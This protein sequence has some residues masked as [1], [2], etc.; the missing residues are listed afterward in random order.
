MSGGYADRLT[1]RPAES[2]GGKLGGK[3]YEEEQSATND[4]VVELASMIR[5]SQCCVVYTGAGI[6]TSCG[7]PDFRGPNGIWTLQAL[8]KPLPKT[9]TTLEL[10]MPSLTHA[11]LAELV[12]RGVVQLIVSQNVDDLHRRSGV[13]ED[14]L[15]ELHRNCF[16]ERSWRFH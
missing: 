14:K 11:A 10:A 3:E 8:G 15:A 1:F 16:I 9:E 13:A 5:Q 2:L 6:S 4:K 12:N 7:I